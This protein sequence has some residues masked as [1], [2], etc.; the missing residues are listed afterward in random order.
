MVLTHPH[1]DHLTGLLEVLQ[2]YKVQQVLY[3]NTDYQTPP[4]QEW[5][6]LIRE[7]GIKSTMAQAGQV[8]DLGTKASNVRGD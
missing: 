4:E 6:S 8:I 5:L 1:L 7:K 2:R 3:L